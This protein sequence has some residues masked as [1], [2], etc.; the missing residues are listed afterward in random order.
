MFKSSNKVK[1]LFIDIVGW[2][3][4]T[5]TWILLII[6]YIGVKYFNNQLTSIDYTW[7][8][9]VGMILYP[10]LWVLLMT[11]DYTDVK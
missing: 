9:V 1:T 3:V 5:S 11:I 6:D 10:I 7:Y 4:V 8:Y 2:I